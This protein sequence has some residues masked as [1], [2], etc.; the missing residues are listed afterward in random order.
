[1]TA[2]DSTPHGRV[3][4]ITNSV[5]GKRYVGQTTQALEARFRQH[6]ALQAKCR[7]LEA[8][9]RKYGHDCFTIMELAT[10]RNQEE[11]NELEARFVVE[12]STLSPRGYNLRQGGGAKGAMHPETKEIMR[13]LAQ[14]PERAAQLKEMRCRPEVREKMQ[15]ARRRRWPELSKKME[16]GRARPE[17][18]ERRIEAVKAA[19]QRPEVLE[20]IRS[21]L[22]EMGA[23][24]EVVA[25]RIE[26]AKRMWADP[27]F[28]AATSQKIS[29]ALRGHKK[30]IDYSDEAK[31]HR[32][33]IAERRWADPVFR[34]KLLER[35]ADPE[36]AK[37]RGEAI[38]V[39]W[40]RRRERLAAEKHAGTDQA[41]LGAR[42]TT[43]D[44]NRETESAA[45][46]LARAFRKGA[47]AS[48]PPDGFIVYQHEV[49]IPP[50][51]NN[52]GIDPMVIECEIELDEACRTA[53]RG[54]LE[55][56]RSTLKQ[57]DH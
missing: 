34:S 3:Y 49:P 8:A 36:V 37:R 6:R 53:L 35:N 55:S 28:K 46:F 31:A 16:A 43:M 47:E 39:G 44:R 4:L 18:Q 1:M 5:N 2:Q 24:P 50:A 27:E 14:S 33:E 42:S 54:L 52:G 51:P 10:A 20:R 21:H 7:A 32:K 15:K 11:L 12:L 38:R 41:S 30:K 56:I 48:S 26:A 45:D 29:A 9:I 57:A 13:K 40:A 23:R 17:V 25:K 22:K 19:Y